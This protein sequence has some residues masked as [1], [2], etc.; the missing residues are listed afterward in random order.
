MSPHNN[1]RDSRSG[2]RSGNLNTVLIS[3]GGSLIVGLLLILGY[4][5]KGIAEDTS[6]TK[7]DVTTIKAQLPYMQQQIGELQSGQTAIWH[8]IGGEQNESPPT[9]A[10]PAGRNP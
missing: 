6:S 2:A 3:V 5:C 8:R 7:T 10:H 1:D 4:F 9:T